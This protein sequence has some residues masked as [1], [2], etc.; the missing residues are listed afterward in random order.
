MNTI[1]D[2]AVSTLKDRIT[3]WFSGKKNELMS[4]ADKEL[5]GTLDKLKPYAPALLGGGA[6]V[7]G[8]GLLASTLGGGEASAAEQAVEQPQYQQPEVRRNVGTAGGYRSGAPGMRVPG[9]SS[10]PM[11]SA[12]DVPGS[13]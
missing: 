2:K 6:L 12:G 3:N 8:A 4:W 5:P 11:F 9:T 10:A 7:G 1:G 13:N